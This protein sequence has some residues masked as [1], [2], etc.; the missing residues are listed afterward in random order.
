MNFDNQKYILINTD[1]KKLKHIVTCF[2]IQK[3][4]SESLTLFNH[5]NTLSVAAIRTNIIIVVVVI[6]K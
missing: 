5:E 2:P 1:I 4:T 3:N 6:L